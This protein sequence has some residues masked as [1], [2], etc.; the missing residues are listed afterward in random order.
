MQNT[1]NFHPFGFNAVGKYVGRAGDDKFTCM[2]YATGT[3][4][5]R[6]SAQEF[7][8]IA[9]PLGDV[10]CCGR[11]VASYVGPDG[12]EI[13]NR[14]IEPPDSHKGGLRSFAV[15]QVASQA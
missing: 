3:P 2:W 7:C 15:P 10:R 14:L 12:L 6:V 8:D 1:E 5:R 11:I 4:G 13:L 9:Y